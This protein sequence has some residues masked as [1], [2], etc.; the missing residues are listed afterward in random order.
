MLE[1][2]V[3]AVGELERAPVVA[4][5]P[6][7]KDEPV[8]APEPRRV[9]VPV[10]AAPQGVAPRLSLLGEVPAKWK[11]GQ[12]QGTGLVAGEWLECR[13]GFMRVPTCVCVRIWFRK[14]AC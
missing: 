1:C 10:V 3:C 11:R 6:Q 5:D 4:S 14:D 12:G 8:V 9:A 2:P 7:P 13:C